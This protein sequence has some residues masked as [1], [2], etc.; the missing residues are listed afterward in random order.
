MPNIMLVPIFEEELRRDMSGETRP[1]VKNSKTNISGT[2]IVSG[3]SSELFE[4]LWEIF[5]PKCIYKFCLFF[6]LP[7]GF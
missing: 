2:G 3:G 1:K 5:P 7:P 4:L 6:L